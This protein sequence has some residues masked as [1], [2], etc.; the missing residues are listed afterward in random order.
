VK[1]I[2]NVP[3]IGNGNIFTLQDADDMFAKTGIDGE[4]INY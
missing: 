3:I 4:I 1:E 2:S